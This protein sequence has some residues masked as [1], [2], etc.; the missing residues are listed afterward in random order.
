MRYI[1]T[2]MQCRIAALIFVCTLCAGTATASDASEFN[3][4]FAAFVAGITTKEVTVNQLDSIK[5]QYKEFLNTYRTTHKG[6][7]TSSETAEYNKQKMAYKK[8]ILTIKTSRTF[9]STKG[10]IKGMIN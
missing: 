3:A 6:N 1:K 9:K 7:M 2:F 4:R 10:A 5:S 8:K